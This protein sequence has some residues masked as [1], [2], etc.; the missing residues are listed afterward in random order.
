MA[1]SWHGERSHLGEEE[2]IDRIAEAVMVL[3]RSGLF[4][5]EP[6]ETQ[7]ERSGIASHDERVRSPTQGVQVEEENP[8][9]LQGGFEYPHVTDRRRRPTRNNP[10]S[11]VFPSPQ[12]NPPLVPPASFTAHKSSTPLPSHASVNT[13]DHPHYTALNETSTL[14]KPGLDVKTAQPH[15]MPWV[16][17][18][19][20][21][22][23]DAQ[24][25]LGRVPRISTFSGS[26][27]KTDASFEAWK[28]EVKCLMNDKSVNRDLL[29]RG[30]RKSLRG[31][32]SKLCIHLGETASVETIMKKLEGVY[33]IVESG[34]TLLQQFY[35]AKQENDES[36][37]VY[38]CRLE[39][40][41]NKA[42][43]RDA[44]AQDQANEMLKSKLWTGLKDERV[45]NAARYKYEMIPDFDTL[46]AELR[47]IEQEIKES[48]GLRAKTYKTPRVVSMPQAEA[49]TDGAVD[50]LTKRMRSIEEKLSKQQD[51]SK[52]LNK[53]LERIDRMEEVNRKENAGQTDQPKENKASNYRGPLRRD[54][55]RAN[56]QRQ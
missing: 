24:S 40:I 10:I 42:I 32:P 23:A 15:S 43:N 30:V 29:L 22:D 37:A 26:N 36:V 1:H 17:I 38:G 51:T 3:R 34:T 44:V 53:I 21:S 33:G 16:T 25:V 52:L 5:V 54:N 19:A 49:Q 20:I 46:R 2:D 28:F 14:R 13:K 47:A 48:D 45:R 11:A 50:E 31:E 41:V 4:T 8:F 39:E 55:Q 12:R 56:P 18:P 9:S 35:N 7:L 6:V 27:T